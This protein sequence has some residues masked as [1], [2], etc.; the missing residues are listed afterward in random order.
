MNDVEIAARRWQ[1]FR[2]AA[3]RAASEAKAHAEELLSEV[4]DIDGDAALGAAL[5]AR[6]L[7]AAEEFIRARVIVE[8]V[9]PEIEKARTKAMVAA[10]L[11]PRA[12]RR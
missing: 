11:L 12:P 9:L 8:R 3:E 7:L 5:D 6:V 1:R 10:P 2:D 4:D